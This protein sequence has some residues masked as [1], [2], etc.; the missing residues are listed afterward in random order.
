METIAANRPTLCAII[1]IIAVA[2]TLLVTLLFRVAI[3]NVSLSQRK[4]FKLLE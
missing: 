1:Q 3:I 4:Q 2:K